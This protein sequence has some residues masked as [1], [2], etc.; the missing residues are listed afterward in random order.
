MV[1]VDEVHGGVG[2]VG[3]FLEVVAAEDGAGVEEGGGLALARGR[4]ECPAAQNFDR[5][6]WRRW[7]RKSRRA[8]GVRQRSGV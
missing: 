7:E 3:E 5:R 1:D 8:S 2:E 6:V 4:Q